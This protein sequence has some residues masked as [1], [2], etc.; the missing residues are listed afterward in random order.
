MKK[1]AAVV[2][3][4]LVPITVLVGPAGAEDAPTS[5]PARVSV[6]AGPV[7][8]A[9][10]TARPASWS[11][12]PDRRTYEWLLDGEGEVIGRDGAYT[13][14]PA[15]AG[16][17]LVVVERVWFG[18]VADESS[19]IPVLV[20]GGPATVVA[21]APVTRAEPAAPVVAQP[22]VSTRRPTLKG[23]AKVGTR[24][25][26]RSRGAWT[27]A[28]TSFAYQWL[29]DGK[30]ITGAT[31]TSYRL[32]SKD[33]GKKVSVR[34]SAVRAGVPTVPATSKASKRVR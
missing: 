10:V 1:L 27:P 16:H 21:P 26:V 11:Q 30:K 7:V 28:P 5:G 6:P 4:V 20:A 33:R 23:V 19:S 3:A 22:T 29:R 24:L 17:T 34:V 31:T 25:T 32:T 13:V 12:A 15:D 9:T 18:A 2:V 8:G 14:T